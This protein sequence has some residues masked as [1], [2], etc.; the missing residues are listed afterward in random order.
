[1]KKY[2]FAVFAFC[3]LSACAGLM[4]DY[5][6]ADASESSQ[7]FWIQQSKA[8]K[9][10][11]PAEAAK[12]LYFTGSAQNINQRLCLKNAETIAVKKIASETARELISRLKRSS[13]LQNDAADNKLKEILEQNIQAGLRGAAVADKYWEKRSYKKEKGAQKDYTSYKCNA[14]VKVK[15]TALAEAL[16]TYK[17]K[18]QK[19]KNKAALESA[20]NSYITELN[21]AQ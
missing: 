9:I 8:H 13:A 17:E 11:A 12:N 18:N 4:S 21:A 20:I 7:P 2:L 1:M 5:D 14:V 10:D 19:N 15:K 16:N 3:L 6:I